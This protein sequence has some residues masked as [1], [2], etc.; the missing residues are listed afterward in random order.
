MRA[1]PIKRDDPT[2]ELRQLRSPD[3]CPPP[4]AAAQP[5]R[6]D[7]YLNRQDSFLKARRLC[8]RAPPELKAQRAGGAIGAPVARAMAQVQSLEGA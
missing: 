7:L 3:A 1:D 4:E 8:Q 6:L 2:A 5:R